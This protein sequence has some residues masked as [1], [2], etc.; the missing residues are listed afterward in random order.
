MG[1]FLFAQLT[2]YDP[3]KSTVRPCSFSLYFSATNTPHCP[4]APET[5]TITAETPRRHSFPTF[6]RAFFVYPKEGLKR[7]ARA[8]APK[9]KKDV[10]PSRRPRRSRRG[11]R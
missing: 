4:S 2:T 9:Q 3:G 11:R 6:L 7:T 8:I 10:T 5:S 1:Q